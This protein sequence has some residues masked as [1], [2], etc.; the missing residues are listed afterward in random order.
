MAFSEK[1]AIG[2][3]AHLMTEIVGF[4]KSMSESQGGGGGRG[5]LVLGWNGRGGGACAKSLVHDP[6]ANPIRSKINPF[7]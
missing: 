1:T 6:R 4:A 7:Q 3:S 2:G 5:I